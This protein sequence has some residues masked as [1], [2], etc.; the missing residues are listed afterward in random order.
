MNRLIN[1]CIIIF[2]LC[3]DYYFNLNVH[4]LF[5]H[6]THLVA[7]QHLLEHQFGQVLFFSW[8]LPCLMSLG[9]HL[10]KLHYYCLSWGFD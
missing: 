10:L 4:K 2:S 8:G 3:R 6:F 7:Q 1:K 5:H 9:R